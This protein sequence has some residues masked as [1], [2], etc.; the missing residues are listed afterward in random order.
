MHVRPDEAD[1]G[2]KVVVAGAV[3]VQQAHHHALT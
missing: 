3:V 2:V 1:R